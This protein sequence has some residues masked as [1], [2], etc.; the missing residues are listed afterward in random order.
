MRRLTRSRAFLNR[1]HRRSRAKQLRKTFRLGARLGRPHGLEPGDD[2]KQ[3]V[4]GQ[5]SAGRRAAYSAGL[6]ALV[7]THLELFPGVPHD[8]VEETRKP[9]DDLNVF[10]PTILAKVL[11]DQP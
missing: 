8:D 10:V 7:Q 4:A 6:Q 3:T 9:D 1:S 2:S 11:L 5:R